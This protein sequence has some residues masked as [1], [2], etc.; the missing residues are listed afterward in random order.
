MSSILLMVQ[1][2]SENERRVPLV[3]KTVPLLRE[4]GISVCLER[5]VGE[6]AGYPDQCY[7]QVKWFDGSQREQYLH[8]VN[9][10]FTLGLPETTSYQSGTLLMGLL[11][12]SQTPVQAL[13]EQGVHVFALEKLPRISRAQSMDVLSSQAAVAG[14]EAVLLAAEASQRFFP[15][16]TTAAGTIRPATVLVIGA[17]VAGLQAIATARRLGA[18]V[19]AYDVRSAVKEQIAS[20]GAKMIDLGVSAESSGGYARELSDD[21]KQQQHDAL[22]KHVA[23]ADVVITT[24]AIPGRPAPRIIDE[25]MV[26]MMQPGSVIMDIA[27]ETGGNCA[28]TK[29]NDVVEHHGVMIHG[30]VNLASRLA[31]HASDMLSRNFY[32]FVRLFVKDGALSIDWDDEVVRATCLNAVIASEAK[33]SC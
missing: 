30:P 24:A 1:K 17:G 8:D 13:K 2:S 6:K 27:A 5:G 15:M 33:Q 11:N 9:V 18:I 19:W 16:L 23:K 32:E 28:L 29:P 7:E 14:Y 26:A 21:E 22:A 25:A 20:L 12:S 3:P 31:Q 4:L 10:V